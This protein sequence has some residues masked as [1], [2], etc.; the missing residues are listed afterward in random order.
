MP[1]Q[2]LSP[3]DDTAS[4]A[5]VDVQT[6]TTR[7]K[8]LVTEGVS[9]GW[10]ESD[11]TAR[12]NAAIA[13][14]CRTIDNAELREQMRKAL[15]TSARKWHY[16]LKMTYRVLDNHLAQKAS[17]QP[18]GI[19]IHDLLRKTPYEKMVEF[20]KV[21]D[22]GTNPGIPIIKDYQ[23][24]VKLAVK[25]MSAEPPKI[26]SGTGK[27]VPLRLR[28]EMAVR[29]SAAVAN[30][31]ELVSSGAKLC[32][33]S[34]HASCSPRCAPYQGRLY[35]LDGTTGTVDG[36]PFS[37][38][39]AALAGPNGDGN[40]CISGYNCRHRAVEYE[41]GSRPPMDYSEA[42][43]KREYAV[44]QQQRRFENQIRQLK[45]EERQL[46]A[47]GMDEEAAALRKQ[48][49]KLTAEYQLYSMEHDRAFYPYRCVID[50]AE[51]AAAGV[52]DG[53]IVEEAVLKAI[54]EK[55][56]PVPVAT[57]TD[58]P[59]I[60]AISSR[61]KL[62]SNRVIATRKQYINHLSKGNNAHEDVF[63]RIR[64][65]LPEIIHDPDYIFVDEKRAD[66]VQFVTIKHHAYVV[67]KL[68]TEDPAKDNTIITAINMGE[69]RVKQYL[70]NK[71]QN[72][73]YKKEE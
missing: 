35:S 29:Y 5:L 7:V 61:F 68:N 51:E 13:E 41:K 10:T 52:V 48:W 23:R 43:M 32:W 57:L 33:I 4:R 46:R 16:E 60:Q 59:S 12:L 53:N 20:R 50:R 14:E 27:T 44:D 19:D 56:G 55:Y 54:D 28:A 65:D 45:T 34:S 38:I 30:L 69:K 24:S 42:E 25:A 58:S 11:L 66:S 1:R 26:A 17:R 22:D 72:V 8:E 3:A 31:Q 73:L 67:V 71:S 39:D 18:L 2:L 40:G 15:V 9:K 70:R 47:A 64:D 63:D 49:Q 37:P 6:A 36:I 21:L 62:K